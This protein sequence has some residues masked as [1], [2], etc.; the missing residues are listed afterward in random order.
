MTTLFE[1]IQSVNSRLS[2]IDVKGKNYVEVNQ[3]ILGFREVFPEGSIE[4]EIL[5]IQDGVVT[6]KAT[7]KD[8]TGK[9]LS[10]GHAQEKESASFIN[11]TSFIENCETSA[12]G[13]ALG[14]I[15]FGATE[16]I[17]SAE[18]VLNA[19][20]NQE[21]NEVKKTVKKNQTVQSTQKEEPIKVTFS[22]SYL[23]ENLLNKAKELGIDLEK[24]KVYYKQDLTNEI[25]QDAINKKMI[26]LSRGTK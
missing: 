10:T 13:R 25:L 4:T 8:N 22:N 26:A 21:K 17:A 12:I 3:R 23:N 16:S 14:I 15:G 5:S 19:I 20:N 9:I 6:M 18:E 7:V 1:H 24:V 2:K 11:K